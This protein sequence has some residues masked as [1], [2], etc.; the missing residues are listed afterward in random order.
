MQLDYAP[1]PP[2]LAEFVAAFYLF[3]ADQEELR[4][5]ERA[6]VAQFRVILDGS[7]DL[8]HPDGRIEEFGRASL[9]GPRNYATEVHG[10]GPVM[11]MFGCGILPAGWAVSVNRSAADCANKVLRAADLMSADLDGYIMDLA[12]CSTLAEM[13]EITV[14][15]ARP[16]YADKSAAPLWFIRTVDAWLE[17]ALVPELADLETATG[18]SRRQIERLCRKHYGAPPKFLVRKYRALRAANAIANGDGEWQD[19]IDGAYYDQSH[20]IRDTKEFTGMTP[21]AIRDR[22]SELSILTF[23]RASLGGEVRPLVSTT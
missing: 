9:F 12:K 14:T 17:A 19:F 10:K 5:I 2:D 6:D 7:A 21:G 23:G 22:R 20:F 4:D 16:F 3:T 18:L 1:P 13:V 8:V 11:R 15:A